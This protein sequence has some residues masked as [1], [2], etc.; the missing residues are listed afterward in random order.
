[1]INYK[2][3]TKP[4]EHQLKA[5]DK[6]VDKK[7]YGYVTDVNRPLPVSQKLAPKEL[8]NISKGPKIQKYQNP[9][10]PAFSRPHI[11][12]YVTE[13][14]QKKSTASITSKMSPRSSLLIVTIFK[15]LVIK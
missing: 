4:Y 13:D 15:S 7:E 2:F 14:P 9:Q 5:L 12:G 11:T 10:R 6:S 8:Y 1:M 3:K